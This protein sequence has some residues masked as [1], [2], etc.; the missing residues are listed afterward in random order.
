MRLGLLS[1]C[2]HH[3]IWFLT[4][5]LL[6]DTG[7]GKSV[8]E[9]FLAV[10]ESDRLWVETS[11]LLI[12]SGPHARPHALFHTSMPLL[13]LSPGPAL[14]LQALLTWQRALPLQSPPLSDICVPWVPSVP[15][16]RSMG[17]WGP[18]WILLFL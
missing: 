14:L 6:A 15:F 13:K 8:R 3:L 4:P 1:K 12:P 2:V 9:E 16:L 7:L 10:E 18:Y 11:H 17:N 5:R